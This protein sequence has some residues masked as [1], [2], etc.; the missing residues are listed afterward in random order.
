MPN[1]DRRLIE[2]LIPI[3]EISAEASR[4]KSLRHGNISTLHL[5]WA[6]RPIVAARAAV[7]GALVPA[8]ADAKER[9]RYMERMRKLCSWDIPNGILEQARKDILDANGGQPPRVLDMFAGGGS[10]PLEALRLGCEAYAVELNPVA[11][12]IELCTLVYPQKYGPSLVTDVKKWGEWVIERAKAQLAEFYPSPPSQSKQHSDEG[13]VQT[14]LS[15]EK[16]ATQ[17][18]DTLTP[19]AYLWT[20]TV[21]CPNPTC[22]A[23]VPLVRQ[24]WLR[25]K[26]GNYVALKMILDHTTKVR[27][28]RVQSATLQGLGFDPEAGSKRGNTVCLHCGAT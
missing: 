28:E 7:Y 25:K 13:M 24:T 14:T 9:D 2:D 21:P 4:E 27:F 3:R 17:S 20:R 16:N 19:I 8:P 26:E 10:I 12:I 23:T 22:G 15:G 5:W 11:H 1:H 6:R 18:K